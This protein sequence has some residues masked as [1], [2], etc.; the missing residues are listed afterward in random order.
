MTI[1]LLAVRTLH[2]GDLVSSLRLLGLGW[3][4]D[5]TT[6]SDNESRP[7]LRRFAGSTVVHAVGGF[8]ALALAMILGPR[9]GKYGPDGK[10]R[11]FPGHNIAYVVIG[12]F[13]LLFGWHAGQGVTGLL[14]RDT[15]QFLVQLGRHSARHS[16]LQRRQQKSNQCV[17][18]PR[19]KRKGS[20]CQSLAC[21]LIQ[22]AWLL[23][24]RP[25]LSLHRLERLTVQAVQLKSEN[26]YAASVENGR[27]K[28]T[29]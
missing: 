21:Q 29:R 26:C 3:R 19:W 4:L 12:T 18:H 13:I 2:R 1:G 7:W 11:P 23:G 5:V 24:W 14:H 25:G 28:R 6:G 9:L 15:H 22:K 17:L 8:A 16:P 27:P 10:P 20:M